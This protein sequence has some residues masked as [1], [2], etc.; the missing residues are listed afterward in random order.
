MRKTKLFAVASTAL[1]VSSIAMSSIALGNQYSGDQEVTTSGDA[2]IVQLPEAFSFSSVTSPT[3]ITHS[4]H[5]QGTAQDAGQNEHLICVNFSSGAANDSFTLDMAAS[6]AFTGN[7]HNKNI[8]LSFN[9]K[10][11]NYG[12][13]FGLSTLGV[14]DNVDTLLGETGATVGADKENVQGNSEFNSSLI[15]YSGNALNTHDG[16]NDGAG[17]SG[18]DGTAG[19]RSAVKGNAAYT[20]E[21]FDAISFENGDANA[22]SVRSPATPAFAGTDATTPAPPVV[23]MQVEAAENPAAVQGNFCSGLMHRADIPVGQIADTY[24]ILFNLTI[25]NN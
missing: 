25:T 11:S 16:Y 2:T 22:D 4:I 9:A 19:E 8:P 14:A 3:A 20:V 21:A 13:M 18:L 6:G 12:V 15:V 23:L 1:L 24:D 5:D 17:D 7:N 10:G